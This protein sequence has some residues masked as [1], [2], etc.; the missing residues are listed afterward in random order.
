M[1]SCYRTSLLC[2]IVK[3]W[4]LFGRFVGRTFE[5]HKR[6]ARE[7][8]PHR[9]GN[10]NNLL[11][12]LPLPLPLPTFIRTPSI[13]RR[14]ITIFWNNC[15]IFVLQNNFLKIHCR[16]VFEPSCQFCLLYVA[17]SSDVYYTSRMLVTLRKP[18]K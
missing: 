4:S 12:P 7:K 18:P 10:L 2:G 1:L 8:S 3:G 11:D 13:K 14:S 6:V 17:K 15:R 9:L 5:C 16:I